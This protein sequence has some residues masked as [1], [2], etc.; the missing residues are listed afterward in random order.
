MLDKRV[1][2]SS[3]EWMRAKIM[4]RIVRLFS[5]LLALNKTKNSFLPTLSSGLIF[6]VSLSSA[7]LIHRLANDWNEERIQCFIVGF[8]RLRLTSF[9]IFSHNLKAIE[10]AMNRKQ[11]SHLFNDLI[12]HFVMIFRLY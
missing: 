12:I 7:Q 4:K 1:K 9:D 6:N 2:S 5:D 11:S 10:K 8:G 3:K